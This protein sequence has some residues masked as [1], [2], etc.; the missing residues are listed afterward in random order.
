MHRIAQD[1]FL[2]A[3]PHWETNQWRIYF[4][5]IT[6]LVSLTVISV[7]KQFSGALPVKRGSAKMM[8]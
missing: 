7:K 2:N 1:T 3:T 8:S 5:N 6:A 4:R